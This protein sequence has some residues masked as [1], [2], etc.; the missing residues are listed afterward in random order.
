MADP[1]TQHMPL[2]FIS[3]PSAKDPNWPARYP[4]R[5]TMDISSFTDWRLFAPNTDAE[6]LRR[7]EAYKH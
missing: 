5:S 4:G 6:W 1:A 3:Q 2:Q 7:G